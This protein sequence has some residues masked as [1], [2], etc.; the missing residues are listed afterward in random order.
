MGF[1]NIQNPKNPDLWRCWSTFSDRWVTDWMPTEAYKQ[2]LLERAVADA[3]IRTLRELETIG[4]Q[5][6]YMTDAEECEYHLALSEKCENCPDRLTEK[7]DRDCEFNL[8]YE[9]YKKR[10]CDTFG[11]ILDRIPDS[12]ES[13]P[14]T[15]QPLKAC[16]CCGRELTYEALRKRF[17]EEIN[18]R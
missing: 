8:S 3:T 17:E 1:C 15:E 10:H 5:S 2:Y 14:E 11:N 16:P 13:N 4:I 12:I 7:C 9:Y 18:G 6:S